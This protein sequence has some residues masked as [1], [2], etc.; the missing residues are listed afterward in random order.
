LRGSGLAK[1]INLWQKGMCSSLKIVNDHK[2]IMAV[3]THILNLYYIPR[4]GLKSFILIEGISPPKYQA[5]MNPYMP[6]SA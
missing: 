6:V 2:K 4:I 1:L 3:F 5:V